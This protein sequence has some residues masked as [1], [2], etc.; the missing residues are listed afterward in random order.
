MYYPYSL[1]SVNVQRYHVLR[2]RLRNFSV[3]VT[4]HQRGVTSFTAGLRTWPFSKLLTHHVVCMSSCMLHIL[5]TKNLWEIEPKAFLKSQ[6]HVYFLPF[7][8]WSK[9]VCFHIQHTYSACSVNNHCFSKTTDFV[10]RIHKLPWG[11]K[12]WSLCC[13]FERHTELQKGV[14]KLGMSFTLKFVRSYLSSWNTSWSFCLSFQIS[15][16]VCREE[17]ERIFSQGT[18]YCRVDYYE[19]K[20]LTYLPIVIF[21]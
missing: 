5:F 4:V 17:Q 13:G 19:A 11:L 18:D 2:S 6:T 7:V 9:A 14:G 15:Q 12:A 20:Q 8:Y 1:F 10:I 3:L 16:E 21:D